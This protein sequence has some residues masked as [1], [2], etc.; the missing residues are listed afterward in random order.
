MADQILCDWCDDPKERAVERMEVSNGAD[1]V[2]LH[3]DLCGE[4]STEMTNG[5]LSRRILKAE[6]VQRIQASML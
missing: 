6:K 5:G 1:D 4:H 3:L 2:L